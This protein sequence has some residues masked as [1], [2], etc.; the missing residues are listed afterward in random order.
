MECRI[1]DLQDL[2]YG[3]L[4]GEEAARVRDH[5]S[6]CARCRGDLARLDG[7]KRTLAGAAAA[8]AAHRTVPTAVI[9]LAFAAAL[10]IGLL[11]L[12]APRSTPSD[13]TAVV[14][15]APQDKGKSSAD[16]PGDEPSIKAQIAKLQAALAE[17]TNEKERARIQ[18]S[19]ENLNVR[20]ERLQ[21]GGDKT[22][23]KEKPETPKKPVVKGAPEN[24]ERM[25]A[26]KMEM[27][28]LM[29]K[30][31]STKDPD[32]K[33]KLAKQAQEVDKEMKVLQPPPKAT[34]NMKEVE[35]KLQNNPDDVDALLARGSWLVD[36]GKAEPGMKDLDRAIALK[37]DL[38]P[39]YLKRAIAH[40]ML[41]H[42]PQAWQDAKK[43]ED[44]DMKAGKAIDDTYR[45]LKKLMTPKERKVTGA[46]MEQQV[47][48][49]RDRLEELRSMA[50]NADLSAAERERATRDA[51]RV[52]AEIDRLVAEM[53]SRPAEPEKKIE[54]KK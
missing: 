10:L 45:T 44:L 52:Q 39:A 6:S 54:K 24:E 37:P 11:W 51:D 35:L 20:L 40:A 2:A 48:G 46:D 25:M 38:A 21:S 4:D 17:T 42:Q 30:M 47:A 50:G 49:L 33:A 14:P 34:V 1:V 18:A 36:S 19:I 8:P 32:E 9:P 27:K 7:E 23:M 28:D 5:V 12:L 15:A 16:Q 43:G 26:L 22:A 41:G 3:F 29:E 13:E 31:R 53:K